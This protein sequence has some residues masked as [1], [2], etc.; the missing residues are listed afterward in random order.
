[1]S[2][3]NLPVC[4]PPPGGEALFARYPGAAMTRV[5]VRR[6]VRASLALH[7][8]DRPIAYRVAMPEPGVARIR[9]RD[10]GPR[11][12][13]RD[14]GR[15]RLSRP[16]RPAATWCATSSATSTGLAVTDG[17]GRALPPERWS[18][19]QA[20]LAR[21]QRRARLPRALPGLRLRADRA[22]LVPRRQPRLLERH[23]PV[24]LRRGRARAPRA[25]STVAPP[26]SRWRVDTALPPIAGAPPHLLARRRLR[27][28]GR[29]AVRGRRRTRSQRSRVG[30]T[31]FELALYGRTNADARA[32]RRHPPP[33]GGRDRQDVR[34]RSRFARYLFIVHALPVGSG[35]LEHRASVTMDIAGLVVRGRDRLP[36]LRRSRG[37]RVL[38]RLEREA[39]P[40]RGAGPVR[41]HARELHAPALALRGV[42][43]LPGER[44]HP[45]RRRHLRAAVPEDDRRGLAALRHAAPAA[46]RRRW[47]SCRSRRGSSSTSRRRTSPTARSATTKRG[48]GPAMALD[49][50]LRLASDGARG[51]PEML[52]LLVGPAS[53]APGRPI[54]EADVRGRRR[55]R[56]RGRAMNRF[57]DR[58]VRGTDELPLPALLS[59]RASSCRPA[60]TGTRAPA[61]PR[62]RDPRPQRPRARLDRHRAAAGADRWCA[63]SSRSRRPGGRGS[64]STTR[65]S[66]STARASRAATFAKRIADCP[67]GARVRASPTSGATSCARRALDARRRAPS[68]G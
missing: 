35:G 44:D 59:A 32:P 16:G 47:R 2:V 1:M 56:S 52:R 42:H 14:D 8:A 46:T 53:A 60:P 63:T 41:L 40:R 54:T 12:A 22:H 36:P 62:E 38:P 65:S 9:G 37:A 34:R 39:H 28:A 27:R 6:S 31:Q 15:H 68:A 58:Y 21:R 55:R 11:A 30:R 33:R 29:L 26:R 4:R 49:L 23:Q 5:P 10:A 18:A 50:E 3:A 17:A 57:F 20:A 19:R 25:R 43:R 64:P 45:A 67:P 7:A 61:R 66:P 51:L 13:G 48:S 24:L